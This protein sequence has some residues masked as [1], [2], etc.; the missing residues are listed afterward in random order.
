M[1]KAEKDSEREGGCWGGRKCSKGVARV[2][3][4]VWSLCLENII[5]ENT[6]GRSQ[7]LWAA[8]KEEAWRGGGHDGISCEWQK[9]EGDISL[10]RFPTVVTLE[11]IGQ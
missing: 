3:G 4:S 5:V 2:F 9:Q 8:R 1:G 7:I 6:E 10:P 11:R